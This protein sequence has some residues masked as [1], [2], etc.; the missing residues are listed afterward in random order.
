MIQFRFVLALPAL[1]LALPLSTASDPPRAAADAAE[2]ELRAYDLAAFEVR[3]DRAESRPFVPYT[4]L[5]W[6]DEYKEEDECLGADRLT[7]LVGE[8]FGDEFEYEERGLWIDERGRLVVRGPAALQAEVQRTLAFLESVLAVQLELRVDRIV[9]DSARAALVKQHGVVTAQVASELRALSGP[10]V[11]HE[12]HVLRV[13]PGQTARAQR[14]RE[15][16]VILDYDVEIAQGA[17]ISD[18]IATSVPVGVDLALHAAPANGG[19]ALA[20]LAQVAE[21]DERPRARKHGSQGYAA[22]ESFAERVEAPEMAQSVDLR[23][24][25]LACN[26]FLPD[27]A[28]LVFRAD[29]RLGANAASEA[30]TELIVVERVSGD[31]PR[32]ARFETGGT[33]VRRLELLNAELFAPPRCEAIGHFFNESRSSYG[34]YMFVQDGG[35]WFGGLLRA[36]DHDEVAEMLSEVGSSALELW[37]DGPWILGLDDPDLAEEMRA[38]GVE[39]V[40]LEADIAMLSEAS[41]PLR[42]DLAL[43][44]GGVAEPVVRFVLPVRAGE[45]CA[46]SMGR[47]WVETYDFDVE[48]AQR[49]ATP[50]PMALIAFDGLFLR[51]RTSVGVAGGL[52]I[53]LTGEARLLSR[54]ER[55][56]LGGGLIESV[57]ES[58]YDVLVVSERVLLAPEPAAAEPL[59]IGDPERLALEL[60]VAR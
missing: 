5:W 10:G 24:Y 42:L 31:L 29:A 51:V 12:S 8:L 27:G 44:R 3:V 22:G 52:V 16:A 14:F 48:V 19:I 13:H 54:S 53:E 59:R 23:A 60:R 6:A 41:V 17:C 47:E 2:S 20:L 11:Q 43:R 40:P 39:P 49:A 7:E 35:G 32:L 28:A 57:D 45:D 58:D 37:S 34:Q 21:A 9:L 15:H 50:D 30:I 46:V 26:S 1:L 36:G 33:P 55:F 4:R 56:E 18:P 38:A 25:S